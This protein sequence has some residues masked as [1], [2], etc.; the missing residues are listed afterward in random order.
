MTIAA[1]F[2]LF[3]GSDAA[4]L[5]NPPTGQM[6]VGADAIGGAF[7]K[8]AGTPGGTDGAVIYLG[9][10]IEQLQ[11]IVGAMFTD[12]SELDFTYDDPS[13]TISAV[14]K[15][16]SLL[17]AKL[18]SMAQAT[19]KGRAAGAGTG[20][21]QDLT[22]AAVKTLL[23][24]SASDVSGLG[25]AATDS[26]GVTVPHGGTGVTTIPAH[27]V[28]LGEG[29][30]PLAS[31]AP[32]V[33]GQVLVSQGAS[34]DP[35]FQSVS[36]DVSLS[37]SGVAQVTKLTGNYIT[38]AS[39]LTL[40]TTQPLSLPDATF[41]QNPDGSTNSTGVAGVI[42][43]T[44]ASLANETGTGSGQG[45]LGSAA[46]STQPYNTTDFAGKKFPCHIRKPDSNVVELSDM[47]SSAVGGVDA[48]QP[49]LAFLSFR[50]DLGANLKWR[51]WFYYKRSSDGFW[52][53]FTPDTSV[54]GCFFSAPIVDTIHNQPVSAGFGVPLFGA[55]AAEIAPSS[56][57]NSLLAAMVQATFKMRAAG[58]GTGNPIDGTPAQAKAALA[59]T[60]SDVAGFD[61]Q[62]RT[63]R[64]DQM[65][66]PT[67]AV[68]MNGQKITNGASA[69][70]PSDFAL[71]GQVG[72]AVVTDNST[73]ENVSGTIREKDGGTTN[74]KLAVMPANSIKANATGSSAGATDVVVGANQF[75]ARDS[76]GALGT[77][78]ISDYVINTLAGIANAAA[79]TALI[80]TATTTLAG[81]L[82]ANDKKKLDNEYIDVT[83]N[84]IANF[85]N[86]DSTDNLAAFNT[87]YAATPANSTWFYPAG[88]GY[89]FSAECA[90]NRDIHLRMLGCGRARSI[91]KTTSATANLFHQ[92]IDAFYNTYEELGFQC[93]VTRTAGAAILMDHNA[94]YADVRR[95]EFQ[96]QFNAVVYSGTQAGNVSTM[97]ECHFNSPAAGGAQVTINGANINIFITLTNI[98]VT[99]VNCQGMVINQSGAVQLATND[100]IGGANAL[101]INATA[102]VSAVFSINCFYDQSTLGSTVKIMGT[103]AVSR[104]KFIGCGITCGVV[105]NPSVTALEI[106]GSGTGTSIP[107]GIDLDDCDLYNSG[108]TGTTQGILATGWRGLGVK[109]CRVSGFT[110]GIT[111]IGYNSNGLSKASITGCVIGPTE[112]FAGNTFGI[113]AGSGSFFLGTTYIVYNDLSGN[114]SGPLNLGNIT[115]IVIEKN[116]G[117]LLAPNNQ[118]SQAPLPAA[119]VTKCGVSIPVPA[120]TPR[121]GARVRITI[122]YTNTGTI[123][124]FVPSLH[125]GAGDSSADATIS[126]IPVALA[127]GTAV[128]GGCEIVWDLQ[129]VSS[130]AVIVSF[131]FKNS[132][133]AATGIAATITEFSQ[134]VVQTVPVN[135]QEFIG[136]YASS[137]VNAIVTPQAV[138]YE[139]WQ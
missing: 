59:I 24:I 129:Y 6:K 85:V 67:A 96:G 26:P 82:S 47:L 12:T 119:T 118:G 34:N 56:V 89:R 51:V 64:L 100:F 105:G 104:V 124:T 115:N 113:A 15:A 73:L 72:G 88:A 2:R 45:G 41:T 122:K 121:S 10:T 103:A 21:P 111:L 136:A 84:S 20:D 92:T 40:G 94:A 44:F 112:N 95:C 110:T 114:I 11:D 130:T 8:L 52:T 120:F 132:N 39:N 29:A 75:L 78:T 66:A 54:T 106:A 134:S 69:T 68:S 16:G 19:I 58:T 93:T 48:N 71:L 109:N 139:V 4:L 3:I 43:S 5:A 99:G 86:D 46:A 60:P 127:A 76:A 18:A 9:Y 101:L 108:S 33:A 133:A 38:V 128:N 138:G 83:S 79:L 50:S 22:P 53:P 30:S 57:T 90:Q 81:A 102:T 1:A 35:S 116:G 87:L 97:S 62:V 77:K 42:G 55:E 125:Y 65:A 117:L 135:A 17:N 98:N 126:S 131:A 28:V 91:V 23:A 107:D 49:V 61:T 70:A 63:S 31:A 25:P 137:T 32:G 14:V 7:I 123:Q 36:G 27:A 37:S 74:A 13:G 80:L